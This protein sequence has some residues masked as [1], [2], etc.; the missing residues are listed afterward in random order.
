MG[1]DPEQYPARL[2]EYEV[3]QDQLDIAYLEPNDSEDC[4][5]TF[6]DVLDYCEA[7]DGY[8]P[9]L[10]FRRTGAI[11]DYAYWVWE[12]AD[13]NDKIYV[14]VQT[15]GRSV[16]VGYDEV[17]EWCTPDAYVAYLYARE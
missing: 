7:E 4:P 2:S 17:P 9:E 1:M 15:D 11:G 10:K 6:D 8:R 14:A 13:I 16:V 5:A 12:Y 3:L